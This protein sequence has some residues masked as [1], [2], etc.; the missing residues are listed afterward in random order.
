VCTYVLVDANSFLILSFFRFLQ[1]Y[2]N[3]E[4]DRVYIYSRQ[5][6]IW[7]SVA[8]ASNVVILALWTALAPRKWTRT[9]DSSTDV[10]GRPFS[11]H[12]TCE[13][14]DDAA[15]PFV[16]VLLIIN[17]MALLVSNYWSYRAMDL[18]IEYQENNYISFALGSVL[19]AFILGI[20]ILA[21]L[22][23]EPGP[24]YFVSVG[25]ILLTSFV[26]LCLIFVPKTRNLRRER[27]KQRERNT[28]HFVSRIQSH[29]QSELDS[30]VLVGSPK[31]TSDIGADI[32][33]RSSLNIASSGDSGR[34]VFFGSDR[35]TDDASLPMRPAMSR[36]ASEAVTGEALD[37]GIR[38]TRHPKVRTLVLVV[39]LT[40]HIFV[41]SHHF[42]LSVYQQE[43]HASPANAFSNYSGGSERCLKFTSGGSN[44]SWRGGSGR[45]LQE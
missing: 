2:L 45:D 20:P 24:K 39:Q 34:M 40:H 8:L 1:V 26:V 12:G 36:S 27:S 16:I 14:Q 37:P 44:C 19:E 42:F 7:C 43:E 6:L 41:Y 18:E 22:T 17:C 32:H 15:R 28:E 38:V 9:F 4:F 30:Q 13:S 31:T 35:E 3:P 5:F 33:E 11:W 21:L 25:L 10:Y 29:L 23:K